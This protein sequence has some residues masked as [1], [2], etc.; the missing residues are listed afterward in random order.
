V[1]AATARKNEPKSKAPPKDRNAAF[2]IA[3]DGTSLIASEIAIVSSA[4]AMSRK[5]CHA[6]IDSSSIAEIPSAKWA[7]FVRM[8]AADNA[9]MK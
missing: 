1:A 6:H 5:I 7:K 9:D 2:K 4:T 8:I 3:V